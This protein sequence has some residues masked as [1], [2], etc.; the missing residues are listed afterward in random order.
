MIVL[1]KMIA[2]QFLAELG[3]NVKS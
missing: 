1:T 2:I 3:Q